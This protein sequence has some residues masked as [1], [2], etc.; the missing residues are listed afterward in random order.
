[1]SLS[2]SLDIY[3]YIYIYTYTS[4][5]PYTCIYGY[6]A[7]VGVGGGGLRVGGARALEE[8]VLL[9]I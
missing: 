7:R 4:L 8:G 1:M 5:S 2:L 6:I 9:Q 3:I